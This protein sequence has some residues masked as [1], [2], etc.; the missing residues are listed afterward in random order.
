MNDAL[1]KQNSINSLL[2]TDNTVFT[3]DEMALIWDLDNDQVLWNKVSYLTKTGRLSRIAAG[4]YEVAGKNTNPL[5]LGNKYRTPSYVS[6]DTVLARVGVINQYSETITLAATVSLQTELLGF[7]Y[8]YRQIKPEILANTAGLKQENGVTI[9]DTNR[10]YLD[11]LY[12]NPERYFD[13]EKLIDFDKCLNMAEIY[14]K[15]NLIAEIKERRVR[16]VA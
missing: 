1:K 3:L 14:C 11:A 15:D 7:R 13:N 12:L 16:N 4:I 5:E 9:A 2:L 6:F 8:V 10:A